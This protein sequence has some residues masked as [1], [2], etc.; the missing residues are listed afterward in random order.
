MFEC[1]PRKDLNTC[2]PERGDGN[3]WKYASEKVVLQ[4]PE[5]CKFIQMCPAP[6][7]TPRPKELGLVLFWKMLQKP[8]LHNLTCDIS[9]PLSAIFVDS[10]GANQ[11]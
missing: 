2:E 8:L 11:G 6:P 5:P 9:V 1:S 3:F 7:S 10:Q 4:T